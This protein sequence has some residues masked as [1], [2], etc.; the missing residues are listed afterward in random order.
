[1]KKR[2]LIVEDDISNQVDILRHLEKTNQLSCESCRD[3]G[4]ALEQLKSGTYDAIVLDIMTPYG[5]ASGLLKAETDPRLRNAGLRLLSYWRE[6]EK[7]E[8]RK[9]IWVSIITARGDSE[10][11]DEIDKLLR[12]EDDQGEKL[13]KEYYKPYNIDRLVDDLL[14]K[15][16]NLASKIPKDLLDIFDD[17]ETS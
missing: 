14:Q 11:N 7:K 8:G 5:S 15:G 17:E 3:V 1:M 6:T 4:E 16:L 10:V 13:G 12:R 9:P 2:V